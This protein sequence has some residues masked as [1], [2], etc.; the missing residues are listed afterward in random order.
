[1]EC[2]NGKLRD[3]EKVTKNF[4]KPESQLIRGLQ[5]YHNYF[6]GHEG[7]SGKTPADAAG[8]KIKGENR[9]VTVIQN[10][11]LLN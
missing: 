10:M 1:M 2:F 5:I 9:W 8:I 7:L 6:K 3:R 11:K 4:K